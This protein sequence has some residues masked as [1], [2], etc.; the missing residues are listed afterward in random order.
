MPASPEQIR[1]MLQSNSFGDRIKG[2]NFIRELEP[3]IGFDL[4]LPAIEDENSRVRYA[5]VC[6]LD[7]L[8]VKD[9]ERT[10]TILR[11]L[12]AN[13]PEI[14]VKAAAADAIG[15][16]K[17]TEAFDDL[18]LAYRETEE[19]LLQFSIIAALGE[20]GDPR[21]FDL[22]QNALESGNGLLQTA[23]IGAMGELGD[24][25]AIPL[26]LP[27]AD[28]RDWQI[29]YRLAQALGNL[30]GAEADSIVQKLTEDETEQVSQ[31][32]KRIIASK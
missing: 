5:A 10:L 28:D 19:W 32:A 21:G 7:K 24:K 26:L 14:D 27:F 15:A 4:I 23:A 6:Q 1:E 3:E 16:L 17:L 22:L 8:G 11:D 30:G 29:R 9:L 31:E 20:F 13:D 25:R 12:L 18:A 2:L